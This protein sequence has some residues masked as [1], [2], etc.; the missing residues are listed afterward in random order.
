MSGELPDAG[1]FG[2]AFEE[3]VEAMTAAA[4]RPES[5][6]A[7]RIREHLGRDP[8]ELPSTTARFPPR[9]HPNV[10]LAL[11][12]VAPDAEVLGYEAPQHAAM[13][14]VGVSELIAGRSTGGAVA[15]GP[16]QYADVEVGDGRIIGCVANGV[17][18]AHHDGAPLVAVVSR[19]E[20]PYGAAI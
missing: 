19:T 7:A 3:F 2:A 11:E 5:G 13:M 12:A 17:H 6:L 20:R 8:R 4:Q 18:L 14:G 16:V 15:A 1:R 10:Q 9:D